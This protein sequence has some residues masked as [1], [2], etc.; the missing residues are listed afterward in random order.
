MAVADRP[1]YWPTLAAMPSTNADDVT[2]ATR[3]TEPERTARRSSS[4]ASA[5]NSSHGIAVSAATWSTGDS[6]ISPSTNAT[7]I[8]DRSF[9]LP[10][11]A[12]QLLAIATDGA[13]MVGPD[14]RRHRSFR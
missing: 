2:I 13:A 1:L 14:R 11:P 10:G 3:H 6:M 8:Y 12:Y 7:S 4:T 9:H 5:P